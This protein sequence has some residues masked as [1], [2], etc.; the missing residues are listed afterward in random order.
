MAPHALALGILVCL[1]LGASAEPA[2]AAAEAPAACGA[3]GEEDCEA[4]EQHALLQVGPAERRQVE[5]HQRQHQQWQGEMTAGGRTSGEICHT[6]APGDC[7][8]A[9]YKHV[10]W[11]KE[12]GIHSN[13]EWYSDPVQ[14][15]ANSTFEQFQ[16]T[17]YHHSTHHC[18][19][20]PCAHCMMQV[21][22]A[23]APPWGPALP[24]LTLGVCVSDG[25]GG[26]YKAAADFD[27][28]SPS[29]CTK[30]SL[31]TIYRWHHDTSCQS[32]PSESG[33][34][35][36]EGSDFPCPFEPDRKCR[37]PASSTAE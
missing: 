37:A 25:Q 34:I 18:T 19:Q 3:V 27:F 20:Q 31:A 28:H 10:L 30:G 7:D 35:F 21:S 8:P 11:A 23:D 33:R 29:F 32:T 16:Y 2:T 36:T 5:Q 22:Y 4:S 14:L 15:N 12:V 17:L 24:P 26:A 6:Y 1:L 9:C 13:P